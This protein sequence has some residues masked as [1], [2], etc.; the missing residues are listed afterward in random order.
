[1]AADDLITWF[2]QRSNGDSSGAPPSLELGSIVRSSANRNPNFP[3]DYLTLSIPTANHLLLLYVCTY[4]CT[5]YMASGWARVY[6]WIEDLA[7]V[8]LSRA[9]VTRAQRQST[10]HRR[11]NR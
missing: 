4:V 9:V 2:V 3:V 6:F 7:G 10:R 11:A 8:A 5:W 1:M